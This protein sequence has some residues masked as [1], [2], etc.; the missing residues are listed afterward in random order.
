[1]PLDNNIQV[2]AAGNTVVLVDYISG[3]L[4]VKITES[5][6]E[7]MNLEMSLAH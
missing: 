3:A 4:I 2:L 1:M 5:T 7:Y 6:F